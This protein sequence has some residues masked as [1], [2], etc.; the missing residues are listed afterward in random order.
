VA[1]LP[2][3]VAKEVV[4]D[5][6]FFATSEYHVPMY[7]LL[8][9]SLAELESPKSVID[10]GCGTGLMLERF[11]THGVEIQGIE[12][13]RHAIALSNVRDAIVR[14][15]LE[16]GVPVKRR[17]D[18]ACCVE[19]AEHLPAR[20]ARRLVEGLAELSDVVVFTAAVPGQGG[21]HHVNERPHAYWEALFA[22][23]GLVR[24]VV[25]EAE[26]KQR[27]ASIPEPVWMHA[28]LMLFRR[29]APTAQ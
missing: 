21:E 7:T 19:V 23:R 13:S 22:D 15:N 6:K 24:D 17:F 28:N 26:L 4:Y 25:R 16:F 12:G 29:A 14:A 11:R 2:F 3:L 9:D 5:R 18:L 1:R 10:V 20:S 8:T 27:I